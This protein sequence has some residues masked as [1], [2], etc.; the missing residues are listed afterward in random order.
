MSG[1]SRHA[2]L[3]GNTPHG[4]FS[5]FEH[6]IR[7]DHAKRVFIIKGG[8]GS[9]KSHFMRSIAK[10]LEAKAYDIE[11]FHC[12]SDADSL[13]AVHFPALAVAWV[14][15]TAPHVIDPKYPGVVDE[16][17]DFGPYCNV[18]L[19]QDK[20]NDIITIQAEVSQA[21]QR[22]FRYLRAAKNIHDNIAAL[23]GSAV[24]W[25]RVNAQTE[26]LI[27]SILGNR[28][29][30]SV[31]GHRRKLFASAITPTG[32]HNFLPSLMD[33]VQKRWVLT[34]EPGTGKA[35]L[36]A[37]VADAAIAHGFD[38]EAYCRPL[39][40]MAMDH[41]II[42][43]LDV[44]VVTSEEP[45]RY[46]R[47]NARTI[48]LNEL[49]DYYVVKRNAPLCSDAWGMYWE[50]IQLAVDALRQAKDVRDVVEGF[51]VEA[52]DFKGIDAL[53]SRTLASF[54]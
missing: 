9:G 4:F 29:V 13:D 35:T 46:E 15:G 2:F 20:K 23:N 21:F 31:T 17:V 36:L 11:Y 7:P 33:P 28:T 42:P 12:S 50:L 27:S 39:D 18:A 51:Y 32:P 3:G 24:A 54:E 47:A 19:L 37:K 48:N 52:M 10:H 43:N 6:L 16:I 5:Y 40:P 44:A 30:S 25:G 8:P 38:V 53:Q 45:H 41:L 22:A 34:G 26:S 1:S 49:R 14:D